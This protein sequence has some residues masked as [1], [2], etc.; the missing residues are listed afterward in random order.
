MLR[1]VGCAFCKLGILC[2]A[3]FQEHISFDANLMDNNE[4]CESDRCQYKQPFVR[5]Q[6]MESPVSYCSK[7]F[8]L[9]ST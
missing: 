2:V 1:I 4:I 3:K 6:V 9:S 8:F 7:L 5:T